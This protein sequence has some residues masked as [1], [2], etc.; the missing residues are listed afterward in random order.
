M[1]ASLALAWIPGEDPWFG[2]EQEYYLLD[3]TTNWPLGWPRG[4]YPDKDT[5]TWRGL[6]PSKSFGA[7]RS[8][9]R[10]A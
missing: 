3:T 6:W 9:R 8:L 7:I 4:K 1:A 2:F 5:V 10:Y